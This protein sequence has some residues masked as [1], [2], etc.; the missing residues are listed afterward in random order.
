MFL[1]PLFYV[2]REFHRFLHRGKA[3][4]S[5][6]LGISPK[7]IHLTLCL[8]QKNPGF[9]KNSLCSLIWPAFDSFESANWPLKSSRNF[10]MWWKICF[11]LW[12]IHK[13]PTQRHLRNAV[14]DA[15]LNSRVPSCLF[16]GRASQRNNIVI[17]I[18][19]N[20]E[21]NFTISYNLHVFLVCQ[22][23]RL[24]LASRRFKS[25]NQAHNNIH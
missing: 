10:R 3:Q 7:L 23:G 18:N 14:F 15:N 5:D 25:T 1:F 8:W 16:A 11:C 4:I 9:R 24:G 6:R 22:T 2:I 21:I 12:S 17:K 19:K 13:L 20:G